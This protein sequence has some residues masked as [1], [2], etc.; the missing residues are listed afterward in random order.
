MINYYLSNKNTSIKF[1]EFIA[2]SHC[3]EEFNKIIFFDDASR[4]IVIWVKTKTL[5]LQQILVNVKIHMMFRVID[6]SER[7]DA[8]WF[9][10]K[11]F[12]HPCLGGKTQL[13]LMKTMFKVV[14][15]QLLHTFKDYKIMPVA[16]VISKK[17]ILAMRRV[18]F[19][20]IIDS[21]FNSR[22]WRVKM[23]V[24]WNI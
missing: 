10:T 16:F 13:A 9:Q 23:N 20:P 12:F 24:K 5:G 15:R 17:Q 21:F 4:S 6:D 22:N 14:N 11:I 1:D 18:E 8:S 2:V 7:G 3:I 19:F